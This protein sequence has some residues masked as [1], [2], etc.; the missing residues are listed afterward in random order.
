[1]KL[2][3]LP[4]RRLRPALPADAFTLTETLVVVA[5]IGILASILLPALLKSKDKGVRTVCINNLKQLHLATA[6]HASDHGDEIPWSNWF[7]GDQPGRRGWLYELDPTQSGPAR[8]VL[9]NGLFWPTLQNPRM[10][11]CPRDT[12]GTPLFDQRAQQISSYVMNGAVN[13][14]RRIRYPCFKMAE[15]T[16][17]DI[18]FWETDEARPNYFNDGASR[19]DEG[20][21]PRHTEGAIMASF[22][23]A[24]EFI[25]FDAWYRE[26]AS[27]NKSRLWCAPDTPDGH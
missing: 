25:K 9:T 1:M 19:P 5:I 22:G 10:Y 8:F 21:S 7:R 3:C 27:P 26:E 13:G 6:M 2:R 11:M 23:G 18:L 20:V 14:Y 17:E 4:R 15:F 24:V 12:P 16:A